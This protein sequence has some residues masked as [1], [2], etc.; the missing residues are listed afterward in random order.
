VQSRLLS[1]LSL[2][3]PLLGK[4]LQKLLS[5]RFHISNNAPD[6]YLRFKDGAVQLQKKSLLKNV[7]FA[8]ASIN[9]TKE[10]QKTALRLQVEDDGKSLRIL[11]T[12]T[13]IAGIDEHAFVRKF[14]LGP[15][16]CIQKLEVQ[17][18][19]ILLD[20]HFLVRP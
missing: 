10:Y 15:D 19:Q 13:G 6:T 7:R 1:G 17:P 16:V 4:A 9:N 14:S 3:S 20:G 11:C 8:C 12:S 5:E 2:A 18:S